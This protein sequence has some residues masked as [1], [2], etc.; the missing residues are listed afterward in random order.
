PQPA[1]RVV[2]GQ[3]DLRRRD[4]RRR[5]V[6]TRVVRTA[7]ARARRRRIRAV[8]RAPA[9]DRA[10]PPGITA[11]VADHS[12]TF[13]ALQAIVVPYA[14]HF[15]VR[16][17]TATTYSLHEEGAGY[18][19]LFASV[20]VRTRDVSF[21]FYPIAVFRELAVPK[22]LAAKATKSHRY[23]LNFATVTK[24]QIVALARRVEAGWKRVEAR[25]AEDPARSYP[26]P[27]GK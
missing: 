3:L 11:G 21:A 27:R 20:Y 1:D 8:A 5:R 22:A 10:H 7:I 18:R 23:A 26:L 13:A 15:T 12:A 16:D 2:G 4:R 6:R 19:T 9:R 17:D 14:K 24:A 25:R